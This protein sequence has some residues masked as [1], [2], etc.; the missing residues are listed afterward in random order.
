MSRMRRRC[1]LSFG[2][3]GLLPF[4]MNAQAAQK[5]TKPRTAR[6][7]AAAK[8]TPTPPLPTRVSGTLVDADSGEPIEGAELLFLQVGEQKP[9]GKTKL[10]IWIHEGK[11]PVA[12]SDKAGAFS[13]ERLPAGEYAMEFTIG[14]SHAPTYK[15]MVT[16]GD[17]EGFLSIQLKDHDQ[18]DLGRIPVRLAKK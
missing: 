16:A 13:Y 10:L 6:P 4:A 9:D 17:G 8:A 14:P 3:F 11:F 18:M 2:L 5:T 12:K 7:R 1:L 15:G